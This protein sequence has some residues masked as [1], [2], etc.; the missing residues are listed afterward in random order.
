MLVLYARMEEL[1]TLH[2]GIANQTLRGQLYL[3]ELRREHPGWN[4]TQCQ[5]W[6]LFL[7]EHLLHNI[8]SMGRKEY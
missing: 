3:S 5:E 6:D 4:I 7:L 8:A 1:V 2:Y